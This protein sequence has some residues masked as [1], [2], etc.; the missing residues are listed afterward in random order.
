[1]TPWD[2]FVETRPYDLPTNVPSLR[3]K[4]R[5]DIAAGRADLKQD[6]G[7]VWRDIGGVIYSGLSARVLWLGGFVRMVDERFVGSMRSC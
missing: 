5:Q 4:P 1:M 2:H 3:T 7:R 6:I